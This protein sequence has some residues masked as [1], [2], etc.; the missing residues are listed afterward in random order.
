MIAAYEA[1]DSDALNAFY[2]PD[3]VLMLPGIPAFVGKD[4]K[5]KDNSKL[6]LM[7]MFDFSQDNLK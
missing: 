7:K 2:L 1:G 4:G 6:A 5:G 3:S